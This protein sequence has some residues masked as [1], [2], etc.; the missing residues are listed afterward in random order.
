[1][2]TPSRDPRLRS[3]PSNTH[4]TPLDTLGQVAEMDTQP[5]DTLRPVRSLPILADVHTKPGR[6]YPPMEILRFTL[7]KW[8]RYLLTA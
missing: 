4:L 7:A 8:H 6:C 2:L 3:T 1:M 5:G